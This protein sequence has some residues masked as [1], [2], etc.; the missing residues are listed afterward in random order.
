MR[1]SA[2][3]HARV[4]RLA[5]SDGEQGGLVRAAREGGAQNEGLRSTRG[6]K[7]ETAAQVHVRSRRGVRKARPGRW[8]LG[9]G[10]A[11]DTQ[12]ARIVRATGRRR[13]ALGG[14]GR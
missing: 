7:G 4:W 2:Q 14:L 11:A 10:Q 3:A 12:R 13:G 1:L 9:G 6:D 8:E 5:E